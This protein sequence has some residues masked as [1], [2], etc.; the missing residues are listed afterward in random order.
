[1]VVF[2]DVPQTSEQY[3]ER[4]AQISPT[5]LPG[6]SSGISQPYEGSIAEREFSSFDE[7]R[8]EEFAPFDEKC[9]EKVGFFEPQ[10]APPVIERY[11]AA[12]VYCG[13]LMAAIQ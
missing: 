2:S 5:I 13:K 12:S 4:I 7:K 10:I 3:L 1:M 8:D 9:G 6:P 11:V